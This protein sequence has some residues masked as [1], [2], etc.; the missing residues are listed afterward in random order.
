MVNFI[1][2]FIL[3]IALALPLGPVTLEILRRGI[4]QGLFESL[5]TVGG[6]LSAE[7]IYFVVVYFGFINFVESNLVK[8][9]L[10]FFGVG[11]LFYLGQGSIKD[12]FK[13]GETQN[14]LINKNSFFAGFLITFLNPLNIFMWIGIIG[15]SLV[16]NSS[17]LISSGVLVGVLDS[18]LVVAIF[19]QAGRKVVSEKNMKYVSLIAGLFMIFYGLKLFFNILAI[20]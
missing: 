12:F 18:Y 3:G 15:G 8:V 14:G 2:N 13:S 20:L 1:D 16:Q 11:F 4:K 6:V 9:S 7:L 5:K 17:F 10:G 19:S